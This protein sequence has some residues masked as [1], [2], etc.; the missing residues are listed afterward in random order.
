[1]YTQILTD[2]DIYNFI[3]KCME[4]ETE[5]TVVNIGR[6]EVS[7][8]LVNELIAEGSVVFKTKNNNMFCCNITANFKD[9]SCAI[10]THSSK[11]IYKK[12]YAEMM[13]ALID[14]RGSEMQLYSEDYM[15]DYNR[16]LRHE[17]EAK[18][19]EAKRHLEKAEQEYNEIYYKAEEPG[20]GIY[21]KNDV[22]ILGCKKMKAR[23]MIY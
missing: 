12:P 21:V 2:E 4:G 7:R 16:D 15:H 3:S 22:T 8:F 9:F 18:I 1:M 23:M 19:K 6:F 20:N 5:H 10:T 13:V 14:E 17:R 11:H